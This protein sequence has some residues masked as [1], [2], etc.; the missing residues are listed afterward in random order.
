MQTI[1]LVEDDVTIASTL[2]QYLEREGYRVVNSIRG[3]E[4][5]ADFRQ[6]SPDLVILD[7]NLPGRTG[8][9]LCPLMRAETNA[10]IIMLSARASEDDKVRCLEYGADDY[11]PKPFSARELVARVN[12]HLLRSNGT[13]VKTDELRVGPVTISFSLYR[14]M[15]GTEEV[16][17]TKTEFDL[18]AHL[19]THVGEVVERDTL[20]KE[21][22]GYERYLSDRTIDTHIKNLRRKFEGFLDI[23]TIRAVGYR[24]TEPNT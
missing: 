17:L 7:I 9:E 10:P 3:D 18:L 4:A 19:A 1:L 8:F 6:A 24:L 12:R 16:R 22:I 11:I 13:K 14:V 23:E 2:S 5:L 20:M 21:I 15:N